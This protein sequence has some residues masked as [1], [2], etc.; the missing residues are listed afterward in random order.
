MPNDATPARPGQGAGSK[1]LPTTGAIAAGPLRHRGARRE[2]CKPAPMMDFK[3]APMMDIVSNRRGFSPCSRWPRWCRRSPRVVASGRLWGTRS[4]SSPRA[5]SAVPA[6]QCWATP[7][8]AVLR[9][10]QLR[11]R[12]VRR[13]CAGDPLSSRLSRSGSYGS[14]YEL[15]RTAGGSCS[16]RCPSGSPRSSSPSRATRGRPRP[17]TS[18]TRPAPAGHPDPGGQDD[19]AARPA[20]LLLGPGHP[21]RLRRAAARCPDL[22]RR[23]RPQALGVAGGDEPKTGDSPDPRRVPCPLS[24]R[25]PSSDGR[26]LPW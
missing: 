20:G 4:G 16:K 15:R 2:E 24:E 17:S 7:G 6:G 18:T 13:A 9:A 3:P 10:A 8:G 26:A 12:V 5:P 21:A 11:R 25:P 19:R 23:E 14:S 1:P 22:P